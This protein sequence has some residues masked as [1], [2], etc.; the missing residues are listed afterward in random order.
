MICQF[1]DQVL[2]DKR[3]ASDHVENTYF[4]TQLDVNQKDSS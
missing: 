2:V 1:A 4:R 3:N